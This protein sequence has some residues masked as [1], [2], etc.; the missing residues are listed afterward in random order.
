M[1]AWKRH[2]HAFGGCDPHAPIAAYAVTTAESRSE[3]KSVPRSARKNQLSAQSVVQ[4]HELTDRPGTRTLE[5][6]ARSQLIKKQ[7]ETRQGQEGT[8]V[9][10]DNGLVD[11]WQGPAMK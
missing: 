8:V 3:G 9:L 5:K 1:S 6:S 7:R 2:R 10:Q 4:A 11:P